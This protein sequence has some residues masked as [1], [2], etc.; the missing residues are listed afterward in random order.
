[1]VEV[2]L[3]DVSEV[4]LAQVSGNIPDELVLMRAARV[5]LGA[6]LLVR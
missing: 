4:A 2:D 5:S 3:C 1:M 6:L